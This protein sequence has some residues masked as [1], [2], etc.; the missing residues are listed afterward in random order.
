MNNIRKCWNLIYIFDLPKDKGLLGFL[1]DK[2]NLTLQKLTLG[3]KFNCTS[4]KTTDIN[5]LKQKYLKPHGK[6]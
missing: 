1:I 3:K 2:K 4:L 6:V 5:S